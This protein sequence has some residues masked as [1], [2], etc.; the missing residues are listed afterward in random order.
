ML[1]AYLDEGGTHAQSPVVTICGLVA[2]ATLWSA[3]EP[4]W[5]EKLGNLRV[6]YFH[7]APCEA[8]D[9]PYKHLS[10]PLRESLFAGVATVIAKH[11][12]I[13]INVA[14]KRAEWDAA[15]A[16][17]ETP[18]ADPYHQVFEFAMQQL[19]QWS[20]SEMDGEPMALMF[21]K[22]PQYQ[23]QGERIFMLYSRSSWGNV[24]E[25]LAFG[26]PE[27][28]IPLQAA[29]LIVYEK[30]KREVAKLTDANIPMRPALRI[31][32]DADVQQ[33]DFPQN[34]LVTAE[35]ILAW[36]LFWGARSS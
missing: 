21:A 10:R 19:A 14:V 17:G 30:T 32:A 4:D 1:Y 11:K 28:I 6:P 9:K 29:D 7:A 2:P 8:G 12:P 24:F 27:S 31:I 3:F 34:K 15:K 36:R 22:H 20:L 18:F 33:I 13:V 23:K 25:P 26:N 35:I 5:Q 16:R